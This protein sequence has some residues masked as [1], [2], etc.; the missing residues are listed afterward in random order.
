M[1]FGTLVLSDTQLED[2]RLLAQKSVESTPDWT[3]RLKPLCDLGLAG[4]SPD[5]SKA[6]GPHC[7]YSITEA[8]RQ[9]LRYLDRRK[10]E[11]HFANAMSVFALAVSIVALIVSIVR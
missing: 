7:I 8:G 5:L 6:P 4:Q 1:D 11:M 2:L 3:T 10:S 9:Y